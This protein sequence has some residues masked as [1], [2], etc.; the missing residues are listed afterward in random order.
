MPSNV[1]EE[2]IDL[3]DMLQQQPAPEAVPPTPVE[4]VLPAAQSIIPLHENITE[5][6]VAIEPPV[7]EVMLHVFT[8]LARLLNYLDLIEEGINQDKTLQRTTILFRLVNEKAQVF[9]RYLNT[10]TALVK[11]HNEELSTTLESISF[12]IT[13]ELNRVYKEEVPAINSTRR[14]VFSRAEL[15]WIYGLLHNCFQQSTITLVQVFDPLLE[16][17]HLFEDYKIKLDQS[18]ILHRELSEL[19][20]Q[21]VKA[22][23]ETGLLMKLS[24]INRLQAFQNETM[25]LLMYRDW[26]T[27]E[28]FVTEIVRTYNSMEDLSPSLHRFARYLE[29][30]LRHVGMRG[31]LINY[32]RIKRNEHIFCAQ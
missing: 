25:H 26:D 9:L 15:T 28:T 21:V 8:E 7:Q 19:L 14:S 29:T 23:K 22:E 31:V 16:G 24:F 13:H 1:Y 4:T 17:S 32:Q 10:H 18:I 5:I 11:K 30:L 3:N 20:R 2:E 12:A 27:F 6:I